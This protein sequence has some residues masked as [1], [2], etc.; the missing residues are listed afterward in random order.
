MFMDSFGKI[1][2]NVCTIFFVFC[3][4]VCLFLCA[5]AFHRYKMFY[6][7]GFAVRG[8]VWEWNKNGGDCWPSDVW[9]TRLWCIA[10]ASQ[11]FTHSNVLVA[12]RKNPSTQKPVPFFPARSQIK[13][14]KF[15]HSQCHSR[16]AS[17][18]WT[19]RR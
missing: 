14:L 11:L 17:E 3:F 19:N 15:N 5:S 9:F 18:Y 7:I 10:F 6:K 13:M 4:S 8:K 12:Y 2:Q 1:G 16:S